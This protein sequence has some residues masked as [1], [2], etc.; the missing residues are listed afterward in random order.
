M[1]ALHPHLTAC[2]APP[3][4]VAAKLDVDMEGYGS[5]SM[6]DDGEWGTP[7]LGPGTAG[8]GPAQFG[9]HS[10]QWAPYDY[11]AYHSQDVPNIDAMPAPWTGPQAHGAAGVL[12]GGHS[13]QGMPAGGQGIYMPPG[14]SPQP[15]TTG[16]GFYELHA[17]G[18]D[19]QS[20]PM[21]AWAH[22][23]PTLL[24][25]MP[26][27]WY[28]Q[29]SGVTVTPVAPRQGG[30][31]A[32]RPAP[33]PRHE[34]PG[35]P[36]PA[37]RSGHVWRSCDASAHRGNGIGQQ[38]G[39]VGGASGGTSAPTAAPTARR[40]LR[41]ASRPSSGADMGFS[42][43]RLLD[44]FP[45]LRSGSGLS[46][47]DDLSWVSSA[48]SEE[49]KGSEEEHRAEEE[50]VEER[51]NRSLQRRSPLSLPERCGSPEG[52]DVWAWEGW[53]QAA[54][55]QGHPSLR[56][57]TQESEVSPCKDKAWSASPDSVRLASAS[58]PPRGEDPASSVVHRVSSSWTPP[59]AGEQ[60]L[61]CTPAT[62]APAR[63]LLLCPP[64][65]PS[66]S[67]PLS[68]SS[69]LAGSGLK[70]C[71]HEEAVSSSTDC[72]RLV[73]PD[74]PEAEQERVLALV[75]S[76]GATVREAALTL[77]VDPELLVE[78]HRHFTS[79]APQNLSSVDKSIYGIISYNSKLHM[80]ARAAAAGRSSLRE[81]EQVL[82]DM[83]EAGIRPSLFTYNKVMELV[84]GCAS[85]G[86]AT[87]AEGEAVLARMRRAG[88]RPDR[89]TLTRL[90]GV[91][92]W[93]AY[94]GKAAVEDGYWVVA[95][96]ANVGVAADDKA[97]R[98]LMRVVAGAARHGEASGVDLDRVMDHAAG[99]KLGPRDMEWFVHGMELLVYLARQ[100][101][102]S[103]ED[104]ERLLERVQ[105][106]GLHPPTQLYQGLMQAA[107]YY[108]NFEGGGSAVPEV[109]RILDLVQVN[110]DKP[111]YSM[112]GAAM[113]V[114]SQEAK[115]G[116]ASVSDGM[117]LL[118]KMEKAY[119][120][121]VW[122]RLGGGGGTGDRALQASS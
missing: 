53:S 42:K 29:P 115:R 24:S 44:G 67:P 38:Q 46:I 88:M 15:G 36:S 41:E 34:P 17:A 68:R 109:E 97:F 59:P 13:P 19:V 87:I 62:I 48:A 77:E 31:S 57:K 111:S 22:P 21:Q 89:E 10:Y 35:G 39:A 58:P 51:E 7:P 108:S 16:D 2:L 40:S 60:P 117:R 47:H 25:D 95:H 9:D 92:A 82:S 74:K 32:A 18:N 8:V 27:T 103:V 37:P 66:S 52:G 6:E 11:P 65:P 101:K 80:C 70:E 121:G 76:A 26:S 100:G 86:R 43:L 91:T 120:K 104:G 81:G 4:S 54:S 102:A 73:L 110:G 99:S 106:E 75:A 45:S 3:F 23:A 94:H 90:L 112:F 30:G 119:G 28:P 105:A 12:S 50:P 61:L 116:R 5:F 20:P 118:N 122:A 14:A 49:H 63:P 113:A 55:C 79:G 107:V 64:G 84:E 85:F 71:V 69:S 72:M 78:L 56:Q 1:A 93:S 98:L 114:L 33:A 96:M 83:E